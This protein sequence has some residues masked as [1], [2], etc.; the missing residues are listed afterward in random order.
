MTRLLLGGLL[1][2]LSSLGLAATA[3]IPPLG[4]TWF[5][6][7]LQESHAPICTELLQAAREAFVGSRPLLEA[8]E[9]NGLR[10]VPPREFSQQHANG[11]QSHFGI[12][13]H[14]GCGGGCEQYQ[15]VASRQPLAYHP[16]VTAAQLDQAPQRSS[17]MPRLFVDESQQPLVLSDDSAPGAPDHSLFL[18]ELDADHNWTL[19]CQIATAPHR[20]SPPASA[21]LVTAR[22]AMDELGRAMGGLARGYGSC[23]SLRSGDRRA[24][25]LPEDLWLA[26]YR[27]WMLYARA[28]RFGDPQ[29]D[30]QV[31]SAAL[32]KWALTG[33]SEFQAVR[34]YRQALERAQPTL[35]HF[36]S[37]AF[38]WSPEQ[39]E[40][41]AQ[42]TLQ[43]AVGNALA[44]PSSG[45]DPFPASERALRQAIL[46]GRPIDDIHQVGGP[47]SDLSIAIEHPQ[48]MQFLLERGADPN[49]RNPFGKTPL[50]YSAQHNQLETARLLLAAG[51]DANAMTI[52]PDDTC[53]YTLQTSKMTA[54]HYAARYASP[55]LIELLLRS[56]AAPFIRSISKAYQ[57][58]RTGTA[59][60]WLK[61]HSASGAQEPNPHIPP[62][63]VRAL[64]QALQVP[65]AEQVQQYAR[66][67]T[68]QAEKDY[69]EGR[70]VPA[71]RALLLAREAS[72]TDARI[73]GN[74]SLVAYKL[75]DI[76]PALEAGQQLIDSSQDAKQLANAWFNQGLVCEAAGLVSYNDRYYCRSGSI[77]AYYQAA[78][79]DSTPARQ[80]K[81]LEQLRAA[82]QARCQVAYAEEEVDILV[83]K[84]YRPSHS[85]PWIGQTLYALY[86]SAISLSAEDV[87]WQLKTRT[88]K[89]REAGTLE[90][91]EWR[92]SVLE[93]HDSLSGAPLQVGD[94]SCVAQR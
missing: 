73:L 39:S 88:I 24:S 58:G 71:Y 80:S 31:D 57:K 13:T 72:P 86:P 63:R 62:D 17:R 8:L 42:A 59:L 65:T 70:L 20:N 32:E 92:L 4:R 35:A 64:A 10:E 44:F 89:P 54:L 75:G 56:G 69:A 51:A 19:V 67:L 84:D 36:Y 93:S 1:T 14:P 26:L 12:Y 41:I 55:E 53:S 61:R 82:K 78:E 74:L 9:P 50:M 52:W 7:T 79:L 11:S 48:A 30:F 33:L 68:L 47:L 45:Y 49:Q 77:Y 83:Q 27:P 22:Q 25:G 90:L 43:A 2:L 76:G 38:H 3:D 16:E 6:P 87:S 29:Q 23:G 81:L 34:S 66:Q 40:S 60:E 94:D 5:Q 15:I 46:E 85:G 28:D 21:E 37:K 18:H 91:G